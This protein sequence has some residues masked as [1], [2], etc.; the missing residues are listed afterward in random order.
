MKRTSR[1]FTLIVLCALCLSALPCLAAEMIGPF[2]LGIGVSTLADSQRALAPAKP[3][4]AGINRYTNG[5]TLKSG[6]A[7]LGLDGLNSVTAIHDASDTLRAVTMEMQK[8]RFNEIFKHLSAKYKL[9]KKDI[10]YVGNSYAEFEA[11]NVI[12]SIDAP[13]MSFEMTVMY[14]DKAVLKA[15]K[16][17]SAAERAQEKKREA[18]KF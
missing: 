10:P 14:I 5:R 8:S 17:Q 13:H 1:L 2:G 6:A 15:F 16:D 11:G 12:I 3:G 4:D 7:G 9:K 18:N